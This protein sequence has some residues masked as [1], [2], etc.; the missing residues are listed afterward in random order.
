MMTSGVRVEVAE[1]VEQL[2][3]HRAAWAAL[4]RE[5]LEPNVFYEPCF[6]LPALRAFATPGDLLVALVLSDPP[7]AQRASG[8]E[9]LGVFPLERRHSSPRL[10]QLT[11][12]L[13]SSLS[14]LRLWADEYTY[15]AVPLLRR[16][17][18]AEAMTAFLDWL[19]AQ[20]YAPPILEINP[21]PLGGQFH[22]ALIEELGRRR[23]QVYVRERD[24]RALFD[25]DCDA[26]TYLARVL[27]SKDRRE[28]QRQRK[29]LQEM[30]KVEIVALEPGADAAA[31]AEQFLALEAGGWKGK[32]GSAFL[33]KE[34][35]ARFFREMFTAAFAEGRL[36]STALRLDG[37]PLAIQLL[38]HA[39]LGAYGFK[40]AYDEAYS[41]YGP[42]TLLEIDLIERSA[43][44][45]AVRWIDSAAVRDHPLFNRIY[46]ER[47]CLEQCFLTPHPALG[48][49][50]SMAPA[51]RWAKASLL[52]GARR[53]LPARNGVEAPE[54]E[55][56]TKPAS[57][58]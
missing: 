55:P 19:A 37:K 44:N 13:S 32:N 12:G 52:A 18:A 5:A 53:W 41:K 16:G 35:D 54:G 30:G 4:G 25:P 23:G 42:G 1:S 56:A 29:R 57:S 48:S 40:T 51:F 22:A 39:G 24:T 17:R 36:T 49:V 11:P 50:L 10:R 9:L 8:P 15:L 7:P 20:K 43:G 31:W 38:L 46:S 27:P 6:L 21:L 2:T 26:A 33:C 34:R 47:R 58:S 28:F 3:A 45:P 14:H